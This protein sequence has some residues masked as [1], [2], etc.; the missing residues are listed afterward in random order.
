[1]IALRRLLAEIYD[2]RIHQLD[3]GLNVDPGRRDRR[4]IR[5]RFVVPHV[6]PDNPF[7]EPPLDSEDWRAEVPG[8]D[9]DAWQFDEYTD[10]GKPADFRR[11]PSES[12]ETPSVAFDDWLLQGER[13]LLLSGA[14]GSGKSTVLRCLALDL[15]RRPEL[16]PA[17]NDRL[18]ARIPLL[19]PFA[20]WS[21]LAAK[22][23]REVGLAEVTRET[24]RAFVPQSELEDYFIEALLDDRLVLLIDGLDEYTDEQ[25]ARTT[26][27]TIETFVRTHDVFTIATAR[28][29]GLR[30]LGVP[31]SGHYVEW[32]VLREWKMIPS[33]EVNPPGYLL[34]E[35][36]ETAGLT[37]R[38]LATRLGCTQQAVARAER[39][40]S[41]STLEFARAWADAFGLD[42]VL[43]FNR[44]RASVIP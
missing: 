21:R 27:A 28:P 31:V 22:E 5:K 33:W 3:P 13:A 42:L 4:D 19:I 2:A 41:N 26:L 29:A 34:R 37:Q 38:S 36:R 43:E 14:P 24:F 15:V 9:D 30:R 8:Q 44:A 40:D 12:S 20:L 6:D 35:A 23:Q 32:R 25:A 7:L 10:A 18:G 16:F 17:V 39:F 1:M 11:P